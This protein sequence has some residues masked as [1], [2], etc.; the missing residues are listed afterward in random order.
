ME[1]NN[2]EDHAIQLSIVIPLFNEDE[3]LGELHEQ[4]VEAVGER[5][6]HEIIFVDDGSTDNSWK[7]IC[8]LREHDENVR[9]IQLTRNYGKSAALQSGF[10]QAEGQ[11][12][13]TMDADL[14][15]DPH[16][17]PEMITMLQE[18]CDLVSGWKKV[19]HDPFNKTVPSKFFNFVTRYVT[20]INL[21]DFNCGLKAYRK[22]VIQNITL[23]GEMHRYIPLIASWEGYQ[24]IGEMVVKHH[25]RK[26]GE[27]KFGVTRFIKGFLDLLT[28][29]IVNKYLQRPMHFF[30]SIGLFFSLVGFLISGY[31]SYR[32]LA[33]GENLSD[34]PLLLMGV[35]LIVLGV[36][37]FSTGILGEMINKNNSGRQKPNIREYI[38]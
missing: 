35:L 37:F 17:I 21:H 3:S 6:T 30:G 16:E 12:I 24:R 4:I 2:T 11:W 8:E 27:T 15:D 10:E 36:Q 19:R 25:P 31:L 26:Y 7:K 32:K 20:G 1:Q 22:E 9:G 13:V 29:I 18:E 14:Q 33:Y 23:Y 38:E 34:R 28:I 5:Y